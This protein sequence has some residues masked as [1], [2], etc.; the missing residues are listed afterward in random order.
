MQR[1]VTRLPTSTKLWLRAAELEP[2]AN[3]KKAV[4]RRALELIPS[5]VKLWRVAVEL[6]DVED[7]RILLGR[8]VE[9]VPHS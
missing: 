5:S 1:A 4:L 7:A 8:A 3:R 6:E 9:C 2:D